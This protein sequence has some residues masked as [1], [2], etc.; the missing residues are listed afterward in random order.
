MV[1]V[2]V[3][4]VRRDWRTAEPEITDSDALKGGVSW[5]PL[6]QALCVRDVSCTASRYTP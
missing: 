6:I 2:S 4:E 3:G 5:C 1:A